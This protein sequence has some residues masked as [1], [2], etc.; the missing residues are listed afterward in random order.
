MKSKIKKEKITKNRT[1]GEYWRETKQETK[2][3]TARMYSWHVK[4]FKDWLRDVEGK[5]IE[6]IENPE[7]TVTK[8]LKYAS[9]EGEL[10]EKKKTSKVALY[11]LWRL[12][13]KFLGWD[14]DKG[15]VTVYGDISEFEPVVLSREDE[16]EVREN[17]EGFYSHRESVLLDLGWYCALRSSE[18]VGF[19][20][21]H[22]DEN[23]MIN[24]PIAKSRKGKTRKKNMQIPKD[25][26]QELERLAETK[27]RKYLTNYSPIQWSAKFSKGYVQEFLGMDR[28]R[29]H[30]F[31]RHSRLVHLAEDLVRGKGE[32][33][34]DV[35]TAFLKIMQISGHENPAVCKKY[36]EKA[37]VR[38]PEL[39]EL[40]DWGE[41]FR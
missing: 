22:L 19:R 8:F 16:K 32:Y 18:L 15:K 41:G 23:Y 34:G 37:N 28:T 36:F 21:R 33:R 6:E 4:W 1:I 3:S 35:R 27:D 31:A 12:F 26:Y 14:F 29:W 39:E 10:W 13:Y 20:P 40:S 9:T 24:A 7:T 5:R 17:T 2:N 11:A 30:D 25:L 38:V